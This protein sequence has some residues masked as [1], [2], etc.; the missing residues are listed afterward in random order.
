MRKMLQLFVRFAFFIF[1]NFTDRQ[2]NI[3][4]TSM[5]L[6]IFVFFI[7]LI[8]LRAIIPYDGIIHRSTDGSSY[9]FLS[10]P[11]T[12]NHASSIEQM[13]PSGNLAVAWFTGGEATPNC[14]IA[15]SLLEIDSP[16]FTA[17]V[18][19]SER[20]NYSNQNPV[21]YWDNE[22]QILHLYYSSRLGYT[23][24]TTSELWHVQSEDQGKQIS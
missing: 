9:A 22:T 17:G 12:G 3:T 5:L 11:R 14:S 8:E 4:E 18:I 20:V 10:P 6:P 23:R 16:K 21:L 13:T 24:E 1:C 2:V 19:V 15:V 7:Q